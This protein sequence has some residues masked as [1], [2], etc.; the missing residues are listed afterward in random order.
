MEDQLHSSNP[1]QGLESIQPF[2]TSFWRARIAFA[3]ILLIV[4]A[5]P[6]RVHA[7][8]TQNSQSSPDDLKQLSLEQLGAV[9]VTTASKEPEEVWKTPAAI[10]VLT[11]EDIRR[12]GATNVPDLLRLVPGVEVAQIDSDH[13]AVGIRGFG[14]EFSKSVLVL[15]DGRS[16]YTPL[17]AG[18][19]WQLQNVVLEDVERIEVIRGPGGTIWGANAV[20]G[21]INIITKSAKDTHGALASVAAGN[22]D[23]G[24]GDFRYGGGNG[25]GFDYRIYGM[26]FG[27]AAEFHPDHSSF[28]EWQMGQGGFRTDWQLNTRDS[29]TLQ[30]DIYKGYDGERV[31]ISLYNPPSIET[32]NEPHNDAGGDLVGR[33]RRQVNEDSDFQLQVYYDRTSQLSPQLDETRNTIDVDFL[34]HLKPNDRNDLLFGAGARW[35]PDSITQKFDTLDFE[36]H[37]ETDSI[38][39]WFLQDQIAIIPDRLSL[40]V[41]SKFE[42]NNY[43]GF[44]I[45]PNVRAIWTPTDHQ[46]L[47]VAVTRAVRTPSRLDT[48]LQLTDF[49]GQAAGSPP[50][51]L[52]LL[53][54]KNF[55]SE[56]L[57]GTEV[58]Y[59]TLVAKKLYVDVAFFHNDY[60]DLYGYGPQSVVVE[61]PPPPTPTRVV[62]Q[63]PITNATKGDTDGIEIAPD[64]KPFAWWELKGSYSFLHLFVQDNAHAGTFNSLLVTP[65]DNGSSPHHQVEMQSWFNL[66]KKF[67]FDVTYRY[68]SGLPAQTS[69]P[70]GPTV[71]DYSTVDT[72]FGWRPNHNL[73]L[74]FVGQNLLQDH[75]AE[76]GGDDGPLV[77][78]RRSFYGKI[79]W[80]Q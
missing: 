16:V 20:N 76:F 77:G 64:W 60:N 44:E 2:P 11:Q 6:V 12:S 8:A 63:L 57:L 21:V 35:S 71:G 3:L 19:Y 54:N 31:Q 32:F 75:H 29:F 24:I 39:S 49:L 73:E 14:S 22:V 79:T 18:V 15:I 58:G 5:V 26:A 27:R 45:Q 38:Y 1:D 4:G 42:H 30:G 47:W 41:G 69:I 33:W 61:A 52:R 25:K 28:D 51:Y 66:P 40:I 37:Q 50:L 56:Q 80:R 34:Y 65:S 7:D 62:L 74:S 46:S 55:E 59:R 17:F 23:Q 53:G 72:R 43:S 10:Y 68:V 78:I 48:D 70:A 13:W 9:E 36:P 67:E